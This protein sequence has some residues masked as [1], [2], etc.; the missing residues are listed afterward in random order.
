MFIFRA[1]G[2]LLS[3]AFFGTISLILSFFDDT[4]RKQNHIARIW[5]RSL[6]RIAGVTVTVE[7]LERITPNGLYVVTPNHL[8]YFDTPVLLGTLPL[9]FRFMAKRGLFSIPLLGTHLARAGHIPVELDDPRAGVRTMNT[10][11]KMIREKRISILVFPEG[12]RA[13]DGH[14]QEFKDGAASIGIRAGATIVPAVLCG[15]SE[16]LSFG[17]GKIQSGHVTLRIGEPIDTSQMSM[18]DRH[19]VTARIR[20]QIVQMLG[21]RI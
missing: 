11:A 14:L 6:L 5:A 15:T 16:V 8:S 4:G 9:Q 7:G 19:S 1:I 17:S 13:P 2:V 18:K 12:G 10:A 21:D 3:T 20:E